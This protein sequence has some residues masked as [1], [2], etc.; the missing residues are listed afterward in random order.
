VALETLRRINSSSSQV[1]SD[2]T[3]IGTAEELFC[4][5]DSEEA[6]TARLLA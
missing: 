5:L 3:L 1:L 2:E 6:K 4:A